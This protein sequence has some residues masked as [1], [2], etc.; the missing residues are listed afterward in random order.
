MSLRDHAIVKKKLIKFDKR[1]SWSA[2]WSEMCSNKDP[3]QGRKGMI[4][5]VI[6]G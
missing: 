6:A 3:L 1:P 2:G 4:D 5:W